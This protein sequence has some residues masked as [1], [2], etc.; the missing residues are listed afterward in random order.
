[1]ARTALAR[2]AGLARRK[3]RRPEARAER[4]ALRSLHHSGTDV[5]QQ[6]QEVVARVGLALV[7]AGRRVVDV[8]KTLHP[9]PQLL[10][11]DLHVSA[12]NLHLRQ[13]ERQASPRST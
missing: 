12:Q 5:V 1:M 2:R 10:V 4:A 11:E 9:D 8:E 7:D 13:S 3:E 6:V